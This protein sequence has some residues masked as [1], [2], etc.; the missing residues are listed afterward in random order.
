MLH[1]SK[2][3]TEF[4]VNCLVDFLKRSGLSD[5]YLG[6]FVVVI[7]VLFGLT[8]LFA[9]TWYKVDSTYFIYVLLWLITIYSNYF[10]HGCILSRVEREFFTK[11]WCGP[12]SFF[13]YV[14]NHKVTKT[15]ANYIIK[16]FIAAPISSIAI[17]KL[18]FYGY[19][20]LSLAL[21]SILVPLLYINSQ[22]T[23]FNPPEISKTKLTGKII[24]I[25]GCSSGIGKTLLKHLY[26]EATVIVLNRKSK[27]S[28]ALQ[29][30]FEKI[31]AINCDLTSFKSVKRAA[32]KISK[33]F[34]QGIDILINNAGISNVD[35]AL[36]K[37]RY[38]IQLQTNFLSHVVLTQE[39]LPLLEKKPN[40]KII[41]HAS[42]SYCIPY[43]RINTEYFK[44]NI[45]IHEL[46]SQVMYQQSKLAMILYSKE[47]QKYTDVKIVCVHPGIVYTELFEKSILPDIVKNMVYLISSTKESAAQ[48]LLG[49]IKN[50]IDSSELYGPS[51]FLLNFNNYG[52][53]L[54]NDEQSKEL[55]DAIS[56]LIH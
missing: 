25:T 10:F 1:P 37:D 54:V 38:E 27:H 6:S 13:G 52:K 55:Y 16:Y 51:V 9:L 3:N 56:V 45:D 33:L 20:I 2:E 23:L 18:F 12:A 32:K 7:H 35:P 34:P 11:E 21:C 29:K 30:E 17:L 22:E 49:A 44:K 36:T 4:V 47:L 28:S 24:V 26:E 39:L 14:L 15:I 8:I 48:Y 43:L 42:I 19:T 46:D 53:Y 31:I 40:S 50:N 5:F 41:N